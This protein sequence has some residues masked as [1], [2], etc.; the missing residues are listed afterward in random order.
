MLAATAVSVV[1][2]LEAQGL[3]VVGD[4]P[5]GFP[6][7]GPPQVGWTDIR[8][9]LLPAVGVTIVAYSDNVLTARAFADKNDYR[10]DSNQELLALGASNLSAGCRPGLPGEQQRKPHSHR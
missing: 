10:I 6:A 4:I 7:L 2:D 8:Q 3:R 5:S 1:F 9:I